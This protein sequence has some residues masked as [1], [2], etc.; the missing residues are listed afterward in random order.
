MTPVPIVVAALLFAQAATP[1]TAPAAP[2]TTPKAAS[3][4]AAP[5]VAAT[6]LPVT[7]VYK[8]KGTIDANHKVIVWLFTDPNISASSRPIDTKALTKNNDTVTFTDVKQ[9]VYLFAAYDEK[10]GYDGL[11]GP[12]PDGIPATIY[13]KVAGGPAM[14]VKPGSAATKFTFD[15]SVRW[16]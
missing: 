10:G 11:S 15:D 13:K 6:D 9:P 12:P 3:K 5:V 4:S 1:K 2:K 16:K 8:G 7:V 14:A